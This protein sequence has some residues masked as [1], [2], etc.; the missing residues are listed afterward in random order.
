MT[1]EQRQT[2]RAALVIA[3]D[4][5][6]EAI[7]KLDQADA[8]YDIGLGDTDAIPGLCRIAC[9]HVSLLCGVATQLTGMQAACQAQEGG[10]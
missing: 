8:L 7:C 10:L 4:S 9:D 5:A 6:H 2:A 3:R 1:P